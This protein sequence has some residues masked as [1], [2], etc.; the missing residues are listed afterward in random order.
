MRTALAD[1]ALTYQLKA[2]SNKV[3]NKQHG[4]PETSH[5]ILGKG[6]K[7]QVLQIMSLQ[8]TMINNRRHATPPIKARVQNE[9]HAS[10]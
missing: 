3:Q 2:K 4:S 9:S 8:L 1:R 6:N 10:V 7:T 5:N